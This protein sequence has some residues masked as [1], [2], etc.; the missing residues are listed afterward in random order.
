M[1][2]GIIKSIGVI[3]EIKKVNESLLYYLNCPEIF[4][5]VTDGS[6]VC[7]SGVC[8]TV[9]NKVDSSLVFEVMPET[10]RK[11]IFKNKKV[12]DKV[13]LESSLQVG[14]DLGG[15]FVYGHVNTV[16][17]VVGIEKEGNDKLVSI[18][19]DEEYKKYLV[20]EGSI[21]V[22]GVSLTIARVKENIFVV[23]LIEYTLSE[24]TLDTLQ[25][26]DEVN[27]E[28]DMMMKYLEKILSFR[29]TRSE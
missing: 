15:H 14:D 19:V 21:A 5:K 7:V 1:F 20:G 3:K 8:L 11:T 17:K 24:T 29:T 2:T 4:E 18:K 16:G 12:G 26:G 13:N 25:V 22:D 9:T 28:F 23:S 27:I 6:S 10:L